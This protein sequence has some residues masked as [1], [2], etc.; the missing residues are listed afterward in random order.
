M[1]HRLVA[2]LLFASKRARPDIQ[3]TVAFLCT[4]VKAPTEEDYKKL[5]RII[6][7][8]KE[9]IDLTLI[10]G[11]DGSDDLECSR[12]LRHPRRCKKSYW[13]IIDAWAGK[14][15]IYVKETEIGVTKQHGGRVDRSGRRDDICH[16]GE[17]FF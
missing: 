1:F 13:S 3:V 17:I 14:R 10:L 4:R 2:R 15:N 8:V 11:S 16:V 12:I 7:Y 5:G 6:K 9:T